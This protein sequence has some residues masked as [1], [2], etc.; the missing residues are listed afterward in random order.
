[1]SRALLQV[2]KN[3]EYLE[4]YEL[5]GFN[6]SYFE[7]KNIR[8]QS[9]L[10]GM[11]NIELQELVGTNISLSIKPYNNPKTVQKCNLFVDEI[12]FHNFGIQGFSAK[13]RVL[14]EK[15]HE[16]DQQYEQ[17]Y[18]IFEYNLSLRRFIKFNGL[19]EGKKRKSIKNRD[20]SLVLVSATT[21]KVSIKL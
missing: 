16:N 11:N 14:P 6:P 1:M 3:N 17:L 18:A 4:A 10:E 2:S 12:K 9:I 15:N 8:I 5:F 20:S 21:E 19:L 7:N 13:L